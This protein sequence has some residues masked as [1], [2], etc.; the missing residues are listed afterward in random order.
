MLKRLE[1]T[2]HLNWNNLKFDTSW[3]PQGQSNQTAQSQ[4]PAPTIQPVQQPSYDP[5][6]SP[7][8]QQYVQGAVQAAQAGMSNPQIQSGLV[9]ANTDL[10]GLQ[11]ITSNNIQA[12]LNNPNLSEGALTG[13]TAAE[14]QVLANQSIPIQTRI[15]LLQ[16][17]QGQAETAANIPLTAGTTEAS[18]LAG[19]AKPTSISPGQ[20][21]TQLN[22]STGQVSSL[23]N[24]PSFGFGTN[25][26]GTP[27]AQNQVTGQII[28][29]GTQGLGA[30]PPALGSQTGTQSGVAGAV[31]STLQSLGS[32]SDPT[33]SA[34]YTNAV[35]QALANGG[36]PPSNLTAQQQQIVSQILGTMSGGQYSS[37]NS[38]INLANLQAE[39]STAND[40]KASA[41]TATSHLAD[42][43]SLANAV[44]YTNSPIASNIRNQFS[45]SILTDP[46]ITTLQ[47]AIGVVRSE[48]A[49][50][51]GG[52]TP[53]VASQAEA[54]DALPDNLSPSNIAG[55]IANV[56]QLMNQKIQEY[57]NPNNANSLP[58]GL[59]MPSNSSGSA[60]APGSLSL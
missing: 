46:S 60:P 28:P 51:L 30:T 9:Q 31:A 43:Q 23:A 7:A 2:E 24:Q 29:G 41:A 19:L 27:I 8:F 21:L 20:N 34:F 59:Q 36:N 53:T 16:Q 5:Y 17:Q 11:Q 42:L 6:Q 52:G 37:T 18:Y 58:N 47:S 26:A 12:D 14:A 50:V 48:V 49:K 4:T 13:Q 57:S 1:S 54:A 35:N 44:G 25:T 32:G 10:S 40:L 3:Q 55:V 22:P 45:N 15:N 39:Q 56:Q 38:A 33:T